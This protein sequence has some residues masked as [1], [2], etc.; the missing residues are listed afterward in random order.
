AGVVESG[1]ISTDSL[2]LKLGG[3]GSITI[4][5]LQAEK[6]EVRLK[7]AGTVFLAGKVVDQDIHLAGAGSYKGRNLES[8]SAV[9]SLTGAGSA[10]VRVEDM[11]DVKLTGVGS[12]RYY[13]DPIVK[14]RV[15]GI[16]SLKKA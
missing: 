4:D 9:V 3:V 1:Q 2:A 7:G 12:V 14:K 6:L 16:G 5:S 8:E 15:T 13:G 10:E 11:L